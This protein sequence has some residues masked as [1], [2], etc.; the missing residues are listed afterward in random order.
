[1][2]ASEGGLFIRTKNK[3]VMT[4]QEVEFFAQRVADKLSYLQKPILSFDEA[5]KFC[6]LAKSTLYKMTSSREV[7]FYKHGKLV[8]F[9]RVELEAWLTSIRIKP[10]GEVEGELNDFFKGKELCHA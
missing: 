7:P 4:D 5:C 8:Y 10:V 1:M 3:Q 2:D 9:K 6:S